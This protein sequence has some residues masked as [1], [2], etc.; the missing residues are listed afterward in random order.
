MH[1]PV[2]K[3]KLV[4]ETKPDA[5]LRLLLSALPRIEGDK[6]IRPRRFRRRHRHPCRP[7]IG[8]AGE[9]AFVMLDIDVRDLQAL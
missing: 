5:A 3:N 9:N 8:R 6:E 7:R 1:A 4:G 2:A